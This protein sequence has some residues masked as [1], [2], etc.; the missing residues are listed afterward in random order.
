MTSRGRTRSA[1]RRRKELV[2]LPA[3]RRSAIVLGV[4]CLMVGIA[5]VLF[6]AAASWPLRVMGLSLLTGAL[7]LQ[8][9]EP[10][11]AVDEGVLVDRS[12][13]G[14]GF[15]SPVATSS[16]FA[17]QN[18]SSAPNQGSGQVRPDAPAER[19]LVARM[20]GHT[21]TLVVCRVQLSPVMTV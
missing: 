1:H 14:E 4:L 19:R 7:I 9:V 8:Y 12:E 11:E 6:A 17:A 16:Q 15:E 13:Q 18:E 10:G 5:G 21:A 20:Y 2:S 3:G